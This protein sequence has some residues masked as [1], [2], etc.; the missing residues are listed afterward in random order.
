MDHL[1]FA[2]SP[3][4]LEARKDFIARG[5]GERTEAETL[6][7]L[8]QETN[9]RSYTASLDVQNVQRPFRNASIDH[10]KLQ[11]WIEAHPDPESRVVA[12]AIAAHINYIDQ[13]T[14]ERKLAES[15]QDFNKGAAIREPFT[16]ITV[17][18]KSNQWVTELAMR[19]VAALPSDVI[20][21][22]DVNGEAIKIP[23]NNFVL[24]DDSSY[25]GGQLSSDVGEVID[26]LE[27][28]AGATV[29]VVVPF[30]TIDAE[31]KLHEITQEA[32]AKGIK[33]VIAKHEVIPQITDVITDPEIQARMRVMY[34]RG[35]N[36]IDP[37][38]GRTLTYFD[39]KIPDDLSVP[40]TLFGIIRNKDGED[41]TPRDGAG[42]IL[43]IKFIPNVA[44]PYHNPYGISLA[45]ADVEQQMIDQGQSHYLVAAIP[46]VGPQIKDKVGFLK[47]P[48]GNFLAVKY[49]FEDNIQ[50]RAMV[51]TDGRKVTL[52]ENSNKSFLKLAKGD[53]IEVYQ[54]ED[55]LQPVELMFDGEKLVS[56]R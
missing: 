19:G 24:F 43:R 20:D 5:S 40:N 25:T 16:A 29:S 30:L 44:V 46:I 12:Q 35:V 3:I 23:G 38:Q 49:N 32:A 33:I 42:R 4:S 36:D 50:P 56:L 11:Q 27:N 52:G 31:T 10:S 6:A 55:D 15:V 14:F 28:P 26:H 13:A 37:L 51:V 9:N 53:V 21:L 22:A 17:S 2:D 1:R 39:H 34:P 41:V 18:G 47:T 7:A 48:L 54:K 8:Q 45:V